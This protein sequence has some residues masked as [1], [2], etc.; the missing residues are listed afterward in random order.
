MPAPVPA[1]AFAVAGTRSQPEGQVDQVPG[2]APTASPASAS[3][4]PGQGQ[5]SDARLRS[6][7]TKSTKIPREQSEEGPPASVPALGW[8]QWQRQAEERRE[9]GHERKSEAWLGIPAKAPGPQ[10]PQP[11]GQSS[12]G[13]GP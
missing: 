8:G 11:S 5:A 3:T 9:V 2:E 12:A 13:P 7:S 1:S 10:A 6:R 4:G